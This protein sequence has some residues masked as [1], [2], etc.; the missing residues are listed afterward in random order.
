MSTKTQYEELKKCMKDY[1]KRRVSIMYNSTRLLRPL[2]DI[3]LEYLQSYPELKMHTVDDKKE[4]LD[5][6]RL[7]HEN[8]HV[9]YDLQLQCMLC[10]QF[11]GHDDPVHKIYPCKKSQ[12]WETY[13][14][15]ICHCLPCGL[16]LSSSG[17]FYVC[18]SCGIVQSRDDTAKEEEKETKG[19][20]PVCRANNRNHK[21]YKSNIVP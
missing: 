17:S 14:S 15:I 20:L 9:L 10:L 19:T 21:F 13:S 6:D 2:I 12:D 11:F 3:T 5:F 7:T 1:D 8:F 4:W 18:E 16:F